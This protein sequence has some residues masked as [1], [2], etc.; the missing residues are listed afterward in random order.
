[1]G[2]TEYIF[3]HALTQEVAYNSVLIERRQQ[4]HER[5]AAALEAL[6]STSVDEHLP[7]LAYHYGRSANPDKAAQYLT[8]A[9]QQAMNRSAFAEA[10]AQLQQGLERIKKLSETPERDARELELVNTL[11]HVLTITRGGAAPE[12][13]AA[14]ERARDLAE[15]AGNLAQ[16]VVQVF[17]IWRSLLCQGITLLPRRWRTGY[18]TSPSARAAPRALASPAVLS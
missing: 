14:A 4:L 13:R 5:T 1:V 11:A 17:G 18:S 16:L 10:H 6:Y 15:R 9:G 8:R 3:K 2:D 12:S 7:E